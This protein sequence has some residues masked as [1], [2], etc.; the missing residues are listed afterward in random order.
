MKGNYMSSLLTELKAIQ[1]E[2]AP[3]LTG[4]TTNFITKAKRFMMWITVAVLFLVVVQIT[5]GQDTPSIEPT[6]TESGWPG[7]LY[8]LVLSTLAISLILIFA[9]GGAH[10][11]TGKSLLTMG[12]VSLGCL[13][14]T[15]ALGL[16]DF[17]TRD[18]GVFSP[19][20]LRE[21]QNTSTVTP[22]TSIDTIISRLP[23]SVALPRCDSGQYAV[24]TTSSQ[25]R[26]LKVEWLLPVRAEAMV[27]GQWHTIP[28]YGFEPKAEML[29]FC[30]PSQ[31]L[32]VDMPL[33]WSW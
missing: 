11:E 33:T 28:P 27:G 14:L 26:T 4:A 17:L 2:L 3:S 13:L 5:W 1:N 12:V 31:D 20:R 8:A 10:K 18:G 19:E 7:W 21:L 24:V 23:D 9:K 22:A 16:A 6:T 15:D 29:R 25:P 30:A 32:V